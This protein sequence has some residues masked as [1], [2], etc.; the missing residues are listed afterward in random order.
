[1]DKEMIEWML[2]NIQTRL[3]ELYTNSE[4]GG[5]DMDDFNSWINLIRKELMYYQMLRDMKNENKN[6]IE[7]D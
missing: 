5:D 2:D 4:I 7:N 6:N 1:M 3:K